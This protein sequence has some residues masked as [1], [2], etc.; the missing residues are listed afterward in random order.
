MQRDTKKE[1]EKKYEDFFRNGR[2]FGEYSLPLDSEK[3]GPEDK[4]II[5]D[6]NSSFES[7]NFKSYGKLERNS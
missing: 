1:V 5:C 2:E 7:F 4:W 6:S 3:E